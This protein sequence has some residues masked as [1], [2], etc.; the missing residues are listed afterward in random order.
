M[1]DSFPSI[2]GS[3]SLPPIRKISLDGADGLAKKNATR[4]YIFTDSKTEARRMANQLNTQPDITVVGYA[5]TPAEC[6]T[7][8]HLRRDINVLITDVTLGGQDMCGL[9][10]QITSRQPEL[11][12]LCYTFHGEEDCVIRSIQSGAMGYILRGTN[13]DLPNCVRLLQGGG[14]PVSPI[15]AR[16]VLRALYAK[17]RTEHAPRGDTQQLSARESEILQLLAKGIPFAEIGRILSISPHTVT[18]HI[19]KIYRKLQVHSRGEA[20]YEAQCLGLLPEHG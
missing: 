2:S 15:V 1:T 6:E 9:I 18:A 10:Q 3:A 7:A 8:M 20:V 17:S 5:V 4:V 13:E 14:S 12:V 11:N 19:K 16:S